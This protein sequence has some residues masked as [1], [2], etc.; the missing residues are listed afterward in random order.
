[1]LAQ[2]PNIARAILPSPMST[3]RVRPY[4]DLEDAERL[5]TLMTPQ[6]GAAVID[7]WSPTCGPCLAMARDFEHVAGQF[8]PDEVGFYKVDTSKYGQLAVLFRIS[9]VPTILFLLD[10]D[11]LDVVVGKMDARRL[12][13]RTEWLLTKKRRRAKGG[14]IGRLFG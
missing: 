12:G 11:V 10:G 5:E 2:D 1:M 6:G 3:E 7:F 4:V 9:S 8:E 14:L 13:E